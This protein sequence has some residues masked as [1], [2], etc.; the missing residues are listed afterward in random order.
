MSS[1]S[2]QNYIHL[3]TDCVHQ[4]MVT[5][6]VFLTFFVSTSVL[7]TSPSSNAKNRPDKCLVPKQ[8]PETPNKVF[9]YVAQVSMNFFFRQQ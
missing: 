4:L 5:S 6:E 8:H 2:A 1:G 9:E 7:L 3:G